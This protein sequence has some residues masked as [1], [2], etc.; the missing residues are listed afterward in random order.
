MKSL[1][2]L[3]S[4]FIFCSLFGQQTFHLDQILWNFSIPNEYEIKEKDFNFMD[5]KVLLSFSKNFEE[6][7]NTFSATYGESENIKKLTTEIY[8]FSLIDLYKKAYNSTDFS[9]DVQM[10]RLKID[11][12]V[13]YLIRSTIIHLE[14]EYKYISDVY[15]SEMNEKE[16]RVDITYDND[17]DKQV[18]ENSFL[19]ST[20]S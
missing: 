9:A 6:A 16:F 5:S 12:R 20:F 10:E 8:V 13:F 11:N 15:I 1:L 14:T 2:L 19:N 17:E 4:T 3:L 18:L 7:V